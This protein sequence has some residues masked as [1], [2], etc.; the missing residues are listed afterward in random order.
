[1]ERRAST[2]NDAQ[3]SAGQGRPVSTNLV[4]GSQ[5]RIV[6]FPHSVAKYDASS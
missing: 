5:Q 1:M 6:R 4:A 2:L 3:E